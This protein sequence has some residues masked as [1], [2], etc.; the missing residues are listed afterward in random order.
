MMGDARHPDPRLQRTPR[1]LRQWR[2]QIEQQGAI[3]QQR[4]RAEDR[5]REELHD[6]RAK[7]VRGTPA[8]GCADSIK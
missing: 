7:T 4:R 6:S 1:Y 5:I 8:S 2:A 3:E